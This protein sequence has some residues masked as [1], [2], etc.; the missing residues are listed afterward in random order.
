MVVYADNASTTKTSTKVLNSMFPYLSE[1]YGNPS[2]LHTLGRKARSSVEDARE[3]IAKCIGAKDKDEIIFTSGGSESNNL[4]MNI[5]KTKGAVCTSNIEHHS[6]IN[7]I[8]NAITLNV[9]RDGFVSSD[10][11]RYNIEDYKKYYERNMI[12]SVSVMTVNNEIGT[13]QPIE[14]I[15]KI[16][17]EN[18]ILFHTDAVQGI[19]HIPI[20]VN[21]IGIDMMSV[22]GHKIHA[23]K[24]IG[25]LYVDKKY[26]DF[27]PIVNVIKGGQQEN[28]YRAGTEN[29]AYIVGLAKAMEIA[30][31]EELMENRE[32]HTRKLRDKLLDNI[33]NRLDDVYINGDI[34]NR[35]AGNLNIS[36]KG[37]EAESLMLMLDMK[38]I[39]VSSG[40]ACNSK[41]IE[42][43]H[44]LMAIRCEYP[45][46][47][48]RISLNEDNTEKE[49]E[50]MAD[51]I[52]TA[53][54]VLRKANPNY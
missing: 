22:S 18:D 47:T 30:C 45:Y 14:E 39:Y 20:N 42:P 9:D 53:V 54:N 25:F 3:R 7:S 21:K 10:N 44:V 49:I 28:G 34:H 2:S 19:G 50:Y 8:S 26:Q 38:D 33:C 4:A 24:G 27:S 32:F 37:V 12:H 13:I 48:I 46:S 5:I 11:L 16:C 35:I 15:A 29:V 52:V 40:S 41:S 17:K 36:F 43:S 23:P 6:V 1:W 31:N 51:E